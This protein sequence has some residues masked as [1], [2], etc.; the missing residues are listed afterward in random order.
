MY[1]VNQVKLTGSLPPGDVRIFLKDSTYLIDGDYIIGGTLIIEPGTTVLFGPNSRIIDSVGGRII[2]DG[3][4]S[5]RY[6]A[7]PN[8]EDPNVGTCPDPWR[9]PISQGYATLNYFTYE[10]INPNSTYRD[11]T[12]AIRTIRDLTVNPLRNLLDPFY[13]VP[14]N[15]A[16]NIDPTYYTKRLQYTS[17]ENYVYNVLL[18]KTKR[19]I[20]D[21]QPI[22]GGNGRYMVAPYDPDG[23]F[24]DPTDEIVVIPFEKAIMFA[25]ARLYEQPSA[26]IKLRIN[27]WKRVNGADINLIPGAIQLKGQPVNDVSRE[28]GHI[29]VLPGARAAFFRNCTFEGFK[30]RYNS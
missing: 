23:N 20:M 24:S 11:T 15:E 7:N 6:T 17:K 14:V 22:A 12:I 29:V 28:Y 1:A 26:D 30:K 21:F 5:A 25:A 2:A 16:A 10:P 13:P 9:N 8:G 3:F 18:N 19:K 27:P 4:A